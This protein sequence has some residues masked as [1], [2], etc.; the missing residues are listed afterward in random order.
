MNLR[1][2]GRPIAVDAMG[3]DNGL[4]AACDGAAW[5]S[6]HSEGEIVLVGDAEAIA[7]A[8][9]RRPHEPGRLHIV[10]AEGAISM[11]AKPREA[12]AAQPRASMPLAAQ[13]VA[14]GD[15]GALVS[16]GN[17]GALILSCA[18]AFERFEGVRRT[19]LAAVYPTENLHGRHGDPF[20]L[21]LD[22]GANLRV[23]A[24]D[25]VAFAIMGAAYASVVSDNPRP[26]VALLNNGTEPGKGPPEMV[27]AY[28]A[29]MA[30]KAAGAIDFIGNVEGLD[31]PKGT[32]DVVVCDGFTGNVVL[33][34]LEG[35]N[36]TVRRLARTAYRDR[37]SWRFALLL[38]NSGIRRLKSLT[39]WRQYGGAPILGFRELCIK[40]HGRSTGRA[41]SNAICVARKAVDSGLSER[42]AQRLDSPPA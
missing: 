40:A 22:V 12:L 23:D 13:L 8:L 33:K 39:D 24:E 28:A 1:S 36:E 29:L 15:A 32:A 35:V 25:L 26:R 41:L 4:E 17:T 42:I 2:T 11:D 16:A 20:S 31:I 5:L 27:A 19:A 6:R 14:S 3:G 37:I 30:R 38:L 18:Q 21:M 34:M 7:R 10:A 9:D